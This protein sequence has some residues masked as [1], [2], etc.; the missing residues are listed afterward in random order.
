[1]SGEY[2]VSLAGWYFLPG[3][4]TNWGQTIYYGL[5]I[6]A[7]APQPQPGT[8]LFNTHRRNIFTLVIV[9]YLLFS[10]YQ[11]DWQIRRDSDFYA[12]LGIP[13]NADE[14]TV[15]RLLRRIL[16]QAHPDKASPAQRAQAEQV[17]INVKTAYDTLVDPVKR[18][19]YDR[20]GAEMLAWKNCKTI[21]DYVLQGAQNSCVALLST[22]VI[23]FIAQT[24]GQMS[25]GKYVGALMRR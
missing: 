22:L 24:F 25:Y 13:Y 21:Q 11:T 18:F 20:F 4:V 1:M 10:I 19:A 3:L 16:A 5:T 6:R 8:P 15:S 14:K 12:D 9:G 17:F 2:L 23:M 7:G